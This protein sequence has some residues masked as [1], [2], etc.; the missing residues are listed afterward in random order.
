MENAWPAIVSRETFD[1]VQALL[2]S[3]SPKVVHPRRASSECLLSGLIYCVACGTKMAG[4]NAKSGKFLYYHCI[5]GSK[6]GHA[7]KEL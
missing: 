1:R 6:R 3:R 5:N 2:K 4:H 7:T